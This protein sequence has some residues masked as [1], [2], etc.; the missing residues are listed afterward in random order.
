[1]SAEKNK[2][3]SGNMQDIVA[4][5]EQVKKLDDKIQNCVADILHLGVDDSSEGQRKMK[6]DPRTHSHSLSRAT[7]PRRDNY[8]YNTNN[9]EAANY[10]SDT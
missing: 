10:N 3:S 2:N 4:K 8:Y 6:A 5:F 1:L 7:V 9:I